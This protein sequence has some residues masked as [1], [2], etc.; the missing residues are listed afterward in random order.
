MKTLYPAYSDSFRCL[1]GA[2]PDSC[3]RAWEICIDPDTASFYHSVPGALGEKLRSC[4]SV[5][6]EGDAYFPLTEGRCPFWDKD[7]LC[8]IHAA[9]GEAATSTVCRQFPYFIEEYEGFTERCPS[10]SCPAAAELIF[11]ERLDDTVYPVPPATEDPLLELLSAGRAAALKTAARYGFAESA[12]RIR[13]MAQDL[14]EIYD[15]FDPS[16]VIYDFDAVSVD[17]AYAETDASDDAR[18][19]ELTERYLRFLSEG[20]EILTE[21]W[22]GML[23]T[24]LDKAA[25]K[26]SVLCEAE[27]GAAVEPEGTGAVLRYFLYRC[28]L[29]PVNDGEILLWTEFI[30]FSVAACREIAR[31]TGREFSFV[32]RRYSKEIEHDTENVDRILDFLNDLID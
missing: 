18:F 30:L 23:R 31:R 24:A 14:Q 8:E 26:D 21:E 25:E 22:R 27:N 3:C 2:C 15:C 13:A 9:L 7:G 6:E 28:F 19:R 12:V 29:K 5:D 11:A 17:A 16:D 20:T 32:A 1:P 10:L 4:L